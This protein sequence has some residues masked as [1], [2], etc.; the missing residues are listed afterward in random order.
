MNF[1][2]RLTNKLFPRNDMREA[3][4]EH[5]LQDF[6]NAVREENPLDAAQIIDNI[7]NIENNNPNGGIPALVRSNTVD[8][9]PEEHGN[10]HVERLNN[11]RQN[12]ERGVN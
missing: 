1:F 9:Q 5:G 6:E 12:N 2:T 11:Q 4:R 7:N 8:T 3:A 10:G